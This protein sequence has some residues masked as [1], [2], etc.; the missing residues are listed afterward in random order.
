[1]DIIMDIS[2]ICTIPQIQEFLKSDI[3]GQVSSVQS[4]AEVYQWMN[5]LL[6]KAR[7]RYLPK[8]HKRL[9]KEF[10]Q[11]VTGYSEVHLKRLIAKQKRGELVWKKWQKSCFT[12]VY[13]GEDVRLLHHADAVH[14]ISGT[15]MRKVLEREYHEFGRKEYR[16]LANISVSHIYNLRG[17]ESY[18]RLGRIFVKTKARNIAIGIREKPRSYGKPGYFRIDT[19]HQ[20]DLVLNGKTYK[21]V[22]FV[23]VVDEVTQM[24]FVFCVP[25]I[26]EKYMKQVLQ[27][28]WEACPFQILNFHSDNGSEYI[29][30]VVAAFLNRKRIRQTKSRSRKT[31]DNAL[32]EGKNGSVIRKWFG[33]F[34]IPATEHNAGLLNSFCINWL[35]PYLNYHHPCGYATVLRDK[36]GKEKKVYKSEDYTTP[37]EKLK[38]LPNAGQYLQRGV[39][40]DELDLIAYEESDTQFAEKVQKRK[41]QLLSLLKLEVY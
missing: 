18:N 33:Y 39:S 25:A 11:Q 28:L 10:I 15:S 19:V 24:E 26:S 27:W 4:K 9:I 21:S 3:G 14:H 32:V 17:T 1:M 38:S 36:K 13:T 30:K 34:H 16:R 8:K 35:T 20:G 7:Y 31:N 2:H 29:N 40:F 12:Q 23:N 41:N 37:Y 22:Y 6:L 5:T